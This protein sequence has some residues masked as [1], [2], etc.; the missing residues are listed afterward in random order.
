METHHQIN[1][2]LTDERRHWNA[3]D[4]QSFR[5]ADCDIDYYMVVAKVTETPSISKWAAQNFDVERFSFK[6]L[7]EVKVKEE[8]YVKISSR[9]AALGNLVDDDDIIGAWENIRENI[10]A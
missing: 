1:H 10:V 5:R 9:F 8:Y 7:N 6:K 2:V 4:F 3:V